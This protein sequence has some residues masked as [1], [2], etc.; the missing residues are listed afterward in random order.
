MNRRLIVF[1]LVICIFLMNSNG[2]LNAAE[3]E[4]NGNVNTRMGYL[5]KKKQLDQERAAMEVEVAQSNLHSALGRLKLKCD[6][7]TKYREADRKYARH[8]LYK[9]K[10]PPI[11]GKYAPYNVYLFDMDCEIREA[12]YE[13]EIAIANCE[14]NFRTIDYKYQLLLGKTFNQKNE[15]SQG[16]QI[17]EKGKKALAELIKQKE[18]IYHAYLRSFKR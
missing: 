1:C 15:K 7:N 17:L 16:Y 2:I 3:K 11:P 12:A 9:G 18:K 13:L 8:A 14:S 5:L 4:K 10:N 6:F